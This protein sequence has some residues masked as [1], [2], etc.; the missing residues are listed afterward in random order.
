VLEFLRRLLGIGQYSDWARSSTVG[1]GWRL[2][3]RRKCPGKRPSYPPAGDPARL[4]RY[5]LPEIR[6]VDELAARLELT[7]GRLNWLASPY[8]DKARTHYVER[9]IPKRSGGVRRIHAPK[10]VTRWVQ[11]W[12]LENILQRIPPSDAAHGFVKGRSIVSNASCH[13]GK[14]VVLSADIEGFFPS[15]SLA[16]VRGI[17]QWMGYPEDVAR[18]LGVLCTCLVGSRRILPQGAPTSPALAN[19]TCWTLDRRLEGLARKFGAAYTRYADD[20]TFS[21]DKEF[22]NGLKRFLPLLGRIVKDEGF[23]LN[24]AKTRFS[25][26]GNRQVVTG[27]VV[28]QRPNV[29]RARVRRLRAILHNCRVHGLESQN[30]AGD[31]LFLERLRGEVAFVSQVNPTQGAKLRA[32][33]EQIAAA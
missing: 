25:R 22:K 12:I 27:L 23:R 29:P 4:A 26:K 9:E 3:P 6:T 18:T 5:G 15:V 32:E 33:L 19:L 17:F 21:G 1:G 14:A 2:P 28:N 24:K 8:R 31:P 13:A 11:R 10:R 30:R 20:L 7:R 16:T